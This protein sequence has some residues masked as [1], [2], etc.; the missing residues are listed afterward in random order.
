MSPFA[1]SNDQLNYLSVM[2]ERYIWWKQADEALTQ[3]NRVIAQVMEIGSTDDVILLL[4]KFQPLDLANVLSV[5]E[6]GWF[7][8]K[9]W[10][11]WHNY[12]ELE[13]PPLP[14]RSF[15]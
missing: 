9:S 15:S 5:A 8:P 6:Q 10:K 13:T 1:Y 11:F 14:E 12:C 2:A 4:K 3:P 7:S